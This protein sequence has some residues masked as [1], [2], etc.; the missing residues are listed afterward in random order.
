MENQKHGGEN[1]LHWATVCNN[2]P[3]INLLLDRGANIS[4]ETR[5]GFRPLHAAARHGYLEVTNLLILRG[6]NINHYNIDGTTALHEAVRTGTLDVVKALVEHG[7]I[8]LRDHTG[9]TP[10]IMAERLGK[11]DKAEYLRA[12][13]LTELV[14]AS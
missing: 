13:N 14:M 12:A 6:A 7:S 8:N 3:L 1:I 10:L 2:V 5:A 9:E 4:S 11:K